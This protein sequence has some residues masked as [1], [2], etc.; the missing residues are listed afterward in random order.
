MRRFLREYSDEVIIDSQNGNMEIDE[1]VER[2]AVIH[3]GDENGNMSD[4]LPGI[5]YE[6]LNIL[7]PMMLG[8]EKG[9][10]DI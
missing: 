10:T 9:L 2:E 6:V 1:N 5:Q 7:V 3:E 4:Y 8:V